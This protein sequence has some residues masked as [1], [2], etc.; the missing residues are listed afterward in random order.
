MYLSADFGPSIIKVLALS[1][2]AFVAAIFWTPLLT[3]Y[4]YKY[5]M[6]RKEVRQKSPDGSGTPIF[7]KLHEG[8]EIGTPRLG[9]L[10]I[11]ITVL[12]TAIIFYLL[13]LFVGG[14]V[15]QKINFLSRNQT[16]LPLATMVAA[17]LVGLLD[18]L[19]QIYKKGGYAAGGLRFSRRLMV[20]AFIGL[21]GALWFYFR[22]E[23]SMIHVPFVGDFNIG[24]L[25]IPLFVIVMLGV[26]SGGVVDGLDGLS[27]GVFATIFAAFGIIAFFNNQ[28]D[29]AAMA[30]VIMGALLA[31]LWFNI[32]PARFYM[33]ETG[34]LG[35]TTV[36]TVFAFLTDSVFVLPIITLILV[37]ESSSVIIQLASKRL[38]GKKVFLVAP[39]HHH[40]EALGWPSYKVTM[41][42][43]IIS[44][45]AA[46][47][48]VIIRLSG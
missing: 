16:W 24:V 38:R 8:K 10:L 13:S 11:W 22:L 47:I 31:F 29:L 12:G 48:G 32:P 45:V 1:T 36:V 28:I 25:Y 14:P 43:W 33:G 35:L 37:L 26:F 15:L 44:A 40:F 7:A 2:L 18:D 41:R 27:G 46:L 19:L 39:L 21:L 20:V 4:M 9:G 17:S 34:I 42:F 23:Q 5:K 3:H 6:W 30:G